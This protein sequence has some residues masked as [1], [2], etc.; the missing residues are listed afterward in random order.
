ME[1]KYEIK[2]RNGYIK[3]FHKNGCICFG[4]DLNNGEKKGKGK[5]ND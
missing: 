5:I 3:E 1:H 4:G 2:S